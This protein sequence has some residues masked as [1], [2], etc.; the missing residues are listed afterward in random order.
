MKTWCGVQG[1]GMTTRSLRDALPSQ[2][3]DTTLLQSSSLL[4]QHDRNAIADRIGEL[5]FPRDQF[6]AHS[7]VFER[8]L[9]N[10]TDE[11]FKQRWV[12]GARW[13]F[14]ARISGHGRTPSASIYMAK[15]ILPTSG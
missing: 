9:G 13:R 8:R 2:D 4:R 5:C 15:S 12:D 3:D 10:R 14:G 6:L 7:V 1:P 11:N